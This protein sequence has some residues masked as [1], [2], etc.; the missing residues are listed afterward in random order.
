MTHQTAAGSLRPHILTLGTA[1]G[2]KWWKGPRA[3]ERTGIATAVVV[4]ENIYLVDCGHG[5]GRQMARAGLELKNLRG[6][7]LTH[8]HSDHTVDLASLA[9]FGL[10][11]LLDRASDPVKVIGPGNRGMLPKVSP[12]AKVAPQPIFPELPTP[13]TKEMF[14]LLMHAHATDL[15]DRILDSLRP[16]P[17][18]LFEASDIEIPEGIGYHPNDS[19]TPAMEPFVIFEDDLVKVSAIL[20]EHP[21]VAPAF[22][23]RF[24]T[25]EGSVTFSG[26]TAPTENMIALAKDTDLL[27]HEAIDFGWV[28]SVYNHKADEASRAARDHHYKSH[29]GVAD[30]AQIA[31]KAGARQLALHHLVPGTAD[32]AQI[33]QQAAQHF[34]GTFH[35]P[36]DL[37]VIGLRPGS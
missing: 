18:E 28:D 22:G 24:D 15:N 32:A 5:V 9:I 30:A 34:D 35:L 12:R 11:E 14:E 6:I 4:G 21:P 7:F 16:S 20:V 26:D 33:A 10:Y 19:P 25:A 13:G 1:G 17:L 27:V 23:F 31:Q 2:P 36:N 37:S 29:T 8:L 3:G